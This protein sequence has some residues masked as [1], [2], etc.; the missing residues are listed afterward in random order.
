LGEYQLYHAEVKDLPRYVAPGSV[1]LILTDP[2][3]HEK[4]LPLYG[5][6][7]AVAA[8]CL[9]HGGSLVT[10]CGQSCLPQV[11]A[12]MTPR[13][14]YQWQFCM[15]M[16]GK[17]CTI[18]QRG[19][20]NHWRSLLWFSQG[21]LLVGGRYPSK[22]TGDVF[23]G[24]GADKRFH[25]WGQGIGIFAAL[26]TRLTEPGALVCDP[27][28]GGGTV[29]K[30]ALLLGRRFIGLDGDAKAIATTER[31]LQHLSIGDSVQDQLALPEAMKGMRLC[32]SCGHE[33]P[34][35]RKSGK[36]CGDTCRQRAHRAKI[37]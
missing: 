21:S 19:I 22:F 23:R 13:L 24:E 8:T 28:V 30:A 5:I 16:Q 12:L 37:A 29:G 4:S 25:A 27:F 14:V 6:L 17:S 32:L 10:M 36:Y 7:A 33:F 9:K 11:F 2:P 1:D 3:Y 26:I 35:Q 18:F 31:R 20:H 15:L 34:A